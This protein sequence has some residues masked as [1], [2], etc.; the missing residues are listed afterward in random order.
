MTS[1]DAPNSDFACARRTRSNTPLAA[2]VSLNEPVFVE[3]AQ[4]MARRIR[5]EGGGTEAQRIDYGYR[6]TTGRGVKPG[7]QEEV[8]RL[9][10]SQ[11]QRLAEGWI[12]ID[13]IAFSDIAPRGELPGG[14]TPQDVAAWTIVS[15]VL[16]N[17]DETMTKN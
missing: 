13:D 1:F 15:R 17:L 4:A 7:E 11:R 6:L 5:R 10:A 9:L 14:V 12:P 3:A 2:L 8:L 16:L